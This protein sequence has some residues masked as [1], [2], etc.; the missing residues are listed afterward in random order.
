MEHV[1]SGR[2]FGAESV[3]IVRGGRER[4]RDGAKV[5]GGAYD[6]GDV[7]ARRQRMGNVIDR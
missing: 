7:Q 5:L 3:W 6:H 4:D 1:W 2:V